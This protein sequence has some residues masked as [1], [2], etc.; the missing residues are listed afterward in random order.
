V[1]ALI[2]P[3]GTLAKH[4]EVTDAGSHPAEVLADIEALS[5]SAGWR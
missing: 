1:T 4:Y 2:A 5:R 3:D